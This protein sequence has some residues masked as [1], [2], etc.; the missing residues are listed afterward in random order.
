MK[1]TKPALTFSEQLDRLV[2]RGLIVKDHVAAI[3]FLSHINYYRL[4]SYLREFEVDHDSHSVAPGTTFEDVIARYD[5][6]RELRMLLLDAIERIEV[7]FRTQ[8]AYHIAHMTAPFGYLNSNHSAS[9]KSFARNASALF[10]ELDRSKEAFLVNFRSKYQEPDAP[11]SWIVSEVMSLGLISNWYQN[12]RPLNIR[13]E[14]SATYGLN[15][16]LLESVMHHLSHVRNLCAHHS[17]IW[18]RELVVTFQFPKQPHKLSTAIKGTSKSRIYRS[19][20]LVSYLMQII[21]PASTWQDRLM[22]LLSFH[23]PPLESM[24]FPNDWTSRDLWNQKPS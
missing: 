7:S 14:I 8:W 9:Q 5:F 20:A 21:S 6:D 24:G 11:P 23:S 2:S 15:Q 3:H 22:H 17:R 18:N 12:L 4:S 1:F 16:Q 19:L 10:G 13:K